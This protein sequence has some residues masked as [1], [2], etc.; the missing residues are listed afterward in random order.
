MGAEPGRAHVVV[1]GWGHVADELTA[2]LR[3]CAVAVRSGAHAAD[4]AEAFLPDRSPSASGAWPD[5]AAPRAVVVVAHG[6]PPGWA[7]APWQARGIPHLPVVAGGDRVVVGPL[8][9]PGSTACL[10][11]ARPAWDVG[12]RPGCEAPG[13]GLV[14]AAAVATV[15]VLAVLRGDHSLGGI[16]TEIAV[17]K[18][19]VTHRLWNPRPDCGCA[20]V[21]M[22]G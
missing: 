14:L 3:R 11:C 19:S 16:S 2:Q 8:V 4:V 20:Q 1:D 6:R 7:G 17:E 21:R 22:A 9:V 15:T 10:R 18:V 13:G 5:A 12:D